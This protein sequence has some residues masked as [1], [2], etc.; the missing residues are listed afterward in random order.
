MKISASVRRSAAIATV[1]GLAACTTYQPVYQTTPYYPYAEPALGYSQ[2]AP[3]QPPQTGDTQSE[4]QTPQVPVGDGQP[5]PGRPQVYGYPA[6]AYGYPAP[7][8]AYPPPIYYEPPPPVYYGPPYYGP[9]YGPGYYGPVIGFGFGFHGGR[10][11]F[12]RR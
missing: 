12:H 8:Y 5:Q 9:Y 11:G 2:S 1:L 10:H 3:P 4:P 6:P 7:T